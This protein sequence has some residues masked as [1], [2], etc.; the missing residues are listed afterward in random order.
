M[1]ILGQTMSTSFGIDT[2]NT[3][4]VEFSLACDRLLGQG[5]VLRYDVEVASTW[6]SLFN[7]PLYDGFLLHY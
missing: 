7:S 4:Q 1:G 2:A 3:I 5:E 6:S